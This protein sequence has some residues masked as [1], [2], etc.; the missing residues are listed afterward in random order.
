MTCSPIVA[1]DVPT[2]AGALTIVET[3]TGLCDFFKIGSE[4]F[5]AEGPSIV[6]KI[7]DRGA[8]VFLDLKFHD[9]PNTVRAAVRNAARLKVRLVT[10]HA[11]GGMAMLEA[12]AEGAAGGPC[13]VL[14]VT[15]LTSLTAGALSSAWGRAPLEV[16]AEVLRMAELAAAARLLGVVCGGSEAKL[17]RER[18]GVRLEVLVPGLRL[19]GGATHDQARHVDPDQAARAGARYVV[20]GRA[21][22]DAE[23]PRTAMQRVLD[24]L[25]RRS[26]DGHLA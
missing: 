23:D 24:H 8:D 6:D 4:L 1:L 25:I 2:A 21:V 26:A 14:A 11:S 3:L 18:F 12:A 22:T 16:G 15:V 5:T 10:V 17:V 7:H 9:I 19:A 20:V 13:G